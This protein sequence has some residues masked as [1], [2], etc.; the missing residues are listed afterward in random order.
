MFHRTHTLYT[1]STVGGL[2]YREF[3]SVLQF[4]C[5]FNALP[6]HCMVGVVL[7]SKIVG[8]TISKLARQGFYHNVLK[9]PRDPGRQ[10]RGV[11]VCVCV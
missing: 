4:Q 8:M 5:N 6:S 11:C 2:L 1:L 10:S 9:D 3:D 7:S